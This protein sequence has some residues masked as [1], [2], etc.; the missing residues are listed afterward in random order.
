MTN[1]ITVTLKVRNGKLIGVEELSTDFQ[2]ALKYNAAI[3]IYQGTVSKRVYIGQTVH[4]LDRHAQH[5]SGAE[6]KFNTAGFN[7][8]IV[9]FSRLFN[10]SSL[11]DVESQLITYFNADNPNGKVGYDDVII[12]KTGGNTV[13]EYMGR[14]SVSSDVILPLWENELYNNGWVKTPTLEE[15]RT[16][17]LVKY[18]PIK[19]L[20]QEQTALITEVISNPTTNYVI[21]GDA[22]TGKTVLLTHMV[23]RI[24]RERKD[25]VVGVVVQPNWEKTGREIFDIFGMKDDARLTVTT[26]TKL[27]TEGKAY[28]VIIVD[29]SHKLSRR[30]SKQ[31]SAFNSVYDIPAYSTCQSHLEILQRMSTQVILMYDVL[32]AI[33]PANVPRAEFAR[34]TLTYEKRVLKTQFR[35]QA[36]KGKSYTSEDYMNGIKWLLYKDTGL[37]SSGI[38]NFDPFFNKEVFS[39]HTPNAYFGYFDDSPLHRMTD[40]L[41]MDLQLNPEHVDRILS[42]LVEDW[43]QSDGAD[44]TIKHFHEGD[45]HLRWN[46][47]QTNW[48][49][50]KDSDA[51]EQIGSVFAVQG[52]DLNKV[53]V[54]IGKDLKVKGGK[55]EADPD[56]FFNVNGKFNAADM[57]TP[58]N[59]FEFTLFVLNIYYVLLTRGIDGIRVGFWD[60]D[61]FKKY[62]LDTLDIR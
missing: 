35:I 4:F 7:R 23:G 18:S 46:S 26:S 41:G 15:L 34:L 57:A 21:N 29:E 31:M 59:Q 28:D 56:H 9:V 61:D 44:P 39:D 33:R 12:N 58:S 19:I 43:R 53:G 16:R 36:P 40:W 11:D 49:N 38:T 54:L 14:E 52:I 47:T 62:M 1:Y 55:L 30:G 25:A 6:E 27:I 24:L 20:T 10:G 3:Y 51:E 17:A 60:N 48:I 42:G 5:Y 45:I 8:V 37:L 50:S 22:G 32:Q 13:I 2:K